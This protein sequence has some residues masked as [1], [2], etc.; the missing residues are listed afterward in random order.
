MDFVRFVFILGMLIFCVS[1]DL[2][3]YPT[4]IFSVNWSDVKYFS[5][6]YFFVEYM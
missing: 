1:V 6:D 3:V 4:S 5:E 2:S